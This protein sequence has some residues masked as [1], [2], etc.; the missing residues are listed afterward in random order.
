MKVNKTSALTFSPKCACST[1]ERALGSR[2]MTKATKH[3]KFIQKTS[4]YFSQ[5]VLAIFLENFIGC[6]FFPDKYVNRR[7]IKHFKGRKLRGFYS[8]IFFRSRQSFTHSETIAF[9][10]NEN[11]LAR[12]TLC[13]R[14][15]RS[16][17]LKLQNYNLILSKCLLS[18]S[19]KTFRPWKIRRSVRA[20]E[21]KAITRK[22]YRTEHLFIHKSGGFTW[23]FCNE[24]KLRLADIYSGWSHI[25]ST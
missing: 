17:T 3:N 13:Q 8:C 11:F 15:C 25:R 9:C 12:S 6:I 2:D 23:D 16:A 7:G 14:N 21:I 19:S 20:V 22:P 5:L 10:V 4:G 18:T 1:L 24:A